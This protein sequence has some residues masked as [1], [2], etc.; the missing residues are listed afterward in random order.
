MKYLQVEVQEEE[1][2]DPTLPLQKLSR[3]RFI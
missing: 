2:V 3:V 1:E